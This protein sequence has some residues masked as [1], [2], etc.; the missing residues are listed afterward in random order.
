M[1]IVQLR[2]GQICRDV[3]VPNR[4]NAAHDLEVLNRSAA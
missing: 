2:D 1:R 3:P 4:Q